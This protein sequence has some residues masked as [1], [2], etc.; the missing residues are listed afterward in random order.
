MHLDDNQGF[1]RLWASTAS[2]NLADGVLLAGLP[3][4][5][6][7]VTTTP[8]LVAGVQVALMLPM[9]LCAL[10][11]GV[12]AD[13]HDRR[14]LLVTAN[15]GRAIGLGVVLTMLGVTAA[16]AGADWRLVA[17]YTAAALAG[18]TEILADSAAETAVPGLVGRAGLEKAHSR[19]IGTQVVLNDAVGA[20]VGSWLAT[21]GFGWTLGIPAVLYGVAGLVVRTLRLP[22]APSAGPG[23]V[24]TSSVQNDIRAGTSFV[25]NHGLLR[26]MAFGNMAMNL[27]NTAFFAVAVLIL[28]GPMGLPR[29]AF[30]FFLSLLALGGVVG[31]LVA[32]R[33]VARLGQAVTVKSGPVV[34]GAGYGVICLTVNPI[35]TAVAAIGIGASGMLWNVANRV[36]RQ[37]ATPDAVLGRVTATMKVLALA[38]TPVGAVVGGAVGQWLGVRAVGYVAVGSAAMAFLALW[39]IPDHPSPMPNQVFD[40]PHRTR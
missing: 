17:I 38:M 20:P 39:G 4:L 11:S 21:I 32:E 5:A 16:W 9:A 2:A 37:R 30:G 29:S 36:V 1:R 26:R 3:V 35:V 10:P 6:T 18:S 19:L 40:T 7:T 27:G 12:L 34:L 23:G 14:L 25:W 31:S 8:A 13:R 22:A 33:V 28:I 24:T 15:A